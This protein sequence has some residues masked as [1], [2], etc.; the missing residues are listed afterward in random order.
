MRLFTWLCLLVSVVYAGAVIDWSDSD[1]A[2]FESRPVGD[3]FYLFYADWC[4][5]CRRFKPEFESAVKNVLDKYPKLEVI[6]VNLDKAPLLSKT[7]KISHLPT[8][9]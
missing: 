1:I 7:F 2:A 5:A 9:F 6:R 4:G 3:R 8:L